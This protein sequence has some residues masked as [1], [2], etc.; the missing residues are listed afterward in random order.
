M[1]LFVLVKSYVFKYFNDLLLLLMSS[2]ISGTFVCFIYF[3]YLV[4][5]STVSVLVT[6]VKAY[7]LF[8][9]CHQYT[10]YC[11]IIVDGNCYQLHLL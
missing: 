5:I 2:D 11:N 8:Y 1:V 7:F 3:T 9:I 6:L 10:L 4:I